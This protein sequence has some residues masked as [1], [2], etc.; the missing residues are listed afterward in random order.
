M[1]RAHLVGGIAM[2]IC[3]A[4]MLGDYCIESK[5]LRRKSVMILYLSMALIEAILAILSFAG[6]W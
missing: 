6:V 4:S 2:L 1:D 3:M 5:R